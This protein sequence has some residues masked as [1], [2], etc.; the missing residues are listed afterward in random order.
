M[1]KIALLSLV[2]LF[3]SAFLP[4]IVKADG[5]TV[6]TEINYFVLHDETAQVAA[7]N[8]E[9][10]REKLLLA[11][12][13][14]QLADGSVVWIVPVPADPSEIEINILEEF[15]EFAGFDILREAKRSK[16]R[17]DVAA[18]TVATSQ[19][20]SLPLVLPNF[21]RFLGGG[22]G[23]PAVA[24][25]A[26][27]EKE[28]ITTQV[29]TAE[30]ATALYQY[31]KEKNVTI[32][33]G[34]IPVLDE[35]IGRNYAFIAS[36]VKSI[37]AENKERTPAIFVEFPTDKLYYPLKPTSI[38]GEREIPVALYVLG[39]AKPNLYAEIEGFTDYSYFRGR[40]VG[41]T[42]FYDG[43]V[44]SGDFTRIVIGSG[45]G[46]WPRLPTPEAHNFVEDLWMEK[47]DG[48]PMEVKKALVQIAIG[49]ALNSTMGLVSWFFGL[50]LASGALA[51]FMVFRKPKKFA[52][53]GLANFFGLV[54]VPIA[55]FVFAREKGKILPLLG[56][57]G[58]FW[59]LFLAI[60]F[61]VVS[62]TLKYLVFA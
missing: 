26:E 36:W 10:G 28:G 14:G 44:Y 11:V 22:G 16:N 53:I 35:Y 42:E 18:G 24:V 32:P 37:P 60:N 6:V 57:I 30:T 23:V 3:L 4:S 7:I 51:G 55:T 47:L 38:Y 41:P 56:F 19:F 27:V 45:E 49:K 9:D 43:G 34:S 17:V 12:K 46:S 1:K 15:P 5:F 59:L 20:F 52:F 48:A 29:I 2:V 40:S 50:C 39:Y 13:L 61:L 58:L 33:F 8:Y 62:P 31:L 25:H 54:G 21:G